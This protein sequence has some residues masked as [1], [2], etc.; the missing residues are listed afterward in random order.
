[1][2][3]Q[4]RIPVVSGA[5]IGILA[6][7]LGI[8]VARRFMPP[9]PARNALLPTI[10][11]VIGF[12]LI[13]IALVLRNSIELR[14]FQM[15]RHLLRTFLDHIPDNVF[16][17]DRDSRFLRISRSLASYF[18]L[19]NPAQ[20]VGKTDADFFSSEH[21]GRALADEQEILRS[22]KPLAGL[23]EKETW[24]DGHESWVLTTKVP[25]LNHR[26]QVIGTMGVSHDITDRK[27]AEARIHYMALHDAL[28]GLPNR[29]LLHDRLAQAIA[30]AARNQKSVAVLMLDL[31][32]FKNVNDSLGHFT[33]D[34]LLQAASLRLRSCLRDSDIVGR[35]GGD[36][37]VICLPEVATDADI[38][39]VAAK[40]LSSFSPSFQVD[41]QD[42]RM[43][44]SIG[45]SRY[46]LDGEKPETLLQTADAAMYEAKKKAR[47][48]WFFFTPELTEATR[49]RHLLE[50]EL[51][52]AYARSEF[53]LHYQPLV[54]ADLTSITG[55]EAL[56]RW[57][58]P[59]Q[60]MIPPLRFI[61][62]LE[63]MGLMVD[64][65]RWVLLTA[66]RQNVEWQRQGLPPVRV[67]VNISPQ[68]FYR[69]DI[70]A[71]VA[72]VLRETGIDPR[73]LELE[74]TETLT[75]DDTETTI[76][77]MSDL[78]QLGVSLSLDDFG[79]GWSSLSYLRRFKLDRIK[80]DQSF[81]RDIA[82]QPAAEALVRTIIS[83]GRNLGLT[84]V[85]EGVETR[86]QLQYLQKQKCS[87][88]QGFL[89]SPA[90]PAPQCEQLL[91]SSLSGLPLPS[92]AQPAAPQLRLAH[93]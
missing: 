42:L 66:C 69:D 37:F 14:R 63:E 79:T 77:I 82:S 59:T 19:A 4:Q 47:G 91:R 72:D 21:A 53:V 5:V 65:G 30:L 80:I 6:T 56:L 62:H 44:A 83:L 75:L 45:I 2:K 67:A 81:L 68:Q 85:A 38:E 86:Q 31:D 93:R 15:E 46:P 29:T 24:P 17:K 87:E 33:G 48:S 88:I 57:N 32:R 36:E 34:R 43:T 89:Y 50:N 71:T 92:A 54:S 40:I 22:G 58:H 28:T 90:L 39:S 20:A 51:R 11:A 9:E 70:V 26:G 61:P 18:G 64:V 13:V 35:M 78:K 12:A 49:S 73:W 8:M 3:L 52:Q 23:E 27:E 60:G 16:F 84:C 41:G 74:L 7:L 55:L 76:Q 25:L 1:M 10:P